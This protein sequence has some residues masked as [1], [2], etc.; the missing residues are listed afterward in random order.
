MKPMY[1]VLYEEVPEGVEQAAARSAENQS[2]ALL[3]ACGPQSL[4]E[5]THFDVQNGETAIKTNLQ[6]AAGCRVLLYPAMEHFPCACKHSHFLVYCRTC[7]SVR[8]SQLQLCRA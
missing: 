3:C 8:T 5:G 1:S 6:S 4:L 2:D 7:V